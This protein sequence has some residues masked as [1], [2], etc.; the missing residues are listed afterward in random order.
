MP[1][2]AA[3][4]RH[5]RLAFDSSFR[6]RISSLG[7]CLLLVLATLTLASCRQSGPQAP[8]PKTIV[9]KSG[10]KMVLVYAGGWYMGSDSGADDEAPPHKVYVNAFMM[11]ATEVTQAQY[12]ALAVVNPSHYKGDDRPVEQVSWAKAA[13]YCNKRSAA[14]GLEPCY[15]E[16]TATCNFE[17]SGYRLPTE[18][19]WEWACRAGGE[20]TAPRLADAAW[21]A[22][23]SGKTTHPVGEK[24]PNAWGLY[25]MIGNVAEWCNDV[26]DPAYYKIRVDQN[27][28]GPAEGKLRVLRGGAWNSKA[29]ACRPTARAGEYPGFADACFARDATGFRCVRRQGPGE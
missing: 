14:E 7:T 27:P 21:F 5:C 9:T 6:F 29:E 13:V 22:E 11:D 23:N 26:Y 3:F 25:D 8:P 17:A 16:D 15:D 4:I 24:Q 1:P 10:I 20:S 2:D 12:A 28:R 19:E 18:A